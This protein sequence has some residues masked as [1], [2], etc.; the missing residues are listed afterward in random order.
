MEEPENEVQ[1][2][3]EHGVENTRLE[4]QPNELLE[5]VKARLFAEAK[6]RVEKGRE[7]DAKHAFGRK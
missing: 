4:S 6:A 1:R 5:Q 7:Q 3:F 2:Q